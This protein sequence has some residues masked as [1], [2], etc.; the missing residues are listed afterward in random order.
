MSWEVSV[1]SMF[2]GI[3]FVFLSHQSSNSE[4]VNRT[5]SWRDSS[6]ATHYER[7]AGSEDTHQL[8]LDQW[9]L[10]LPTFSDDVCSKTTLTSYFSERV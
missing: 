7:V 2:M 5:I 3:H 9:K 8:T 10:L 6:G 1:Q 4:S